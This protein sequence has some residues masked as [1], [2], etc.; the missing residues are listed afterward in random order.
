MA[1]F[2]KTPSGT[3]KALIRKNS[4]PTVAKTFRTKRDTPLVWW[5]PTSQ[6][7]VSDWV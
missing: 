1:T 7:P 5:S 6:G 3:W 2:V 4:W